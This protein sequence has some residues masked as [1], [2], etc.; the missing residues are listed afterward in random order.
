MAFNL[1]SAFQAEEHLPFTW[2]A[3]HEAAVMFIHGFPGTPAE[4]RPLAKVLHA[5]CWT[6]IAPLLPGFGAQID[7]LDQHSQEDWLSF[8]LLAYAEMCRQYRTVALIGLSMGGALALQLAAHHSPNA[9]ILLAPFWKIEHVLWR[10]MPVLKYVFPSFKPF[11]LF[12]LDFN[13]QA[14]RQGIANFMPELDLDDPSIQRAIMDFALPM[15][16]IDQLRQVG[17]RGY[18]AA[19]RVS[20]PTL[21]IQGRQDDLVKPEVT[22]HLCQRFAKPP[23]Y[24]EVDASHSLSDPSQSS[25]DEIISAISEFLSPF[26]PTRG[27]CHD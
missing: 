17:Q 19:S 2:H 15:N 13:D 1:A 16:L 5:Q 18:D 3:S 14:V 6:T 20:C 23:V 9:L 24:L 10:A 21:V 7:T 8:L 22:R 11:R 4:M 12:K 27:S 26:H 25:R